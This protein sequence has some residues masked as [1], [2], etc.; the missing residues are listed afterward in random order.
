MLSTPPIS[1]NQ[2]DRTSSP[3]QRL[4]STSPQIHPHS[5]G[6]LEKERCPCKL[7]FNTE[8]SSLC[9]VS[10]TFFN[11]ILL[12]V[13]QA[14]VT[15]HDDNNYSVNSLYNQSPLSLP[16]HPSKSVIKSTHMSAGVPNHSPSLQQMKEE[17]LNLGISTTTREGK[18]GKFIY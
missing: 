9:M 1:S 2:S 7:I 17:P 3:E 8:L 4:L 6:A 18:S 16:T 14:Y 12:F 5:P 15:R 10:Y 13:A 11:L